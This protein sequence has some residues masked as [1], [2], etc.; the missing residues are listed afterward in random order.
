M[1]QRMETRPSLPPW[2]MS[3]TTVLL[4]SGAIVTLIWQPRTLWLALGAGMLAVVSWHTFTRLRAT[5]RR[6]AG[7]GA[8]ANTGLFLGV[9]VVAPLLAF[10]LLW[11]GL[12]LILGVTWLLNQAG[13]A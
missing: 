3:V 2:I 8:V 6:T 13:L 7:A 1:A 12:L 10:A 4:A 9:V 5:A 11:T